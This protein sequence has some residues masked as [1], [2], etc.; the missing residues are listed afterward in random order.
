MLQDWVWCAE[1]GSDASMLGVTQVNAEFMDQKTNV[2]RSSE[3]S[4]LTD[5]E[6]PF[7]GIL[8]IKAKECNFPFTRRGFISNTST[9]R[10]DSGKAP[11]SFPKS[12]LRGR[13]HP[14]MKRG[15]K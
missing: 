10:T 13:T 8:L 7:L 5:G 14:Y 9:G 4:L 11:K 2:L 3:D 12:S 15:G 1:I 6:K